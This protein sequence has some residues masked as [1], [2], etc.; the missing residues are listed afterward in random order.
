M[1]SSTRDVIDLYQRHAAAWVRNRG[2]RLTEGVWL[3]RF[4]AVLPDGRRVLDLG[5]GSGSPIARRLIAQGC[6]VT[7]V[8]G[9]ADLIAVCKAAFPEHTWR[10]GDMR[11]TEI[12]QTF[13]GV[14]AWDSLFHLAHDEQR[15][16]FD[17]FRRHC[18][19]NAALMFN[20]GPAHGEA[21]GVFQGEPLYHAS[22]DPAE[23]RSLL[24]EHGFEVVRFTPEDPEC[25]GRSVWLARRL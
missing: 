22:L 4:L 15:R 2:D 21:I 11:L 13:D 20:S 9:S 19:P 1:S 16:M 25:G 24:A 5:C 12:D 8:D 6:A 14:L 18:G 23:Y 17:V 10:V 7:G 3:D